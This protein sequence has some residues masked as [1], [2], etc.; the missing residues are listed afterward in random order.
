LATVR[1]A[2]SIV[3]I[4]RD[5]RL[6]DHVALAAAAE[7][8][9]DVIVAF[10][11]D[12]ALL[13]S[14]RIGA[15]LVQTFFEALRELRGSLRR[16]GSDLAVLEGDCGEQL[17]ALA[18]RSGAQ[19]VFFNEDYE[20]RAIARD[21]RAA[22]ALREAGVSVHSFLDHVCF[23]SDEIRTDADKPY[24]IFTPYRSRWRDRYAIGPRLPVASEDLIEGKLASP[25]EIGSTREIPEPE[26]YGFVSSAAYPHCG[27]ALACDLLEE[28]LE[29]GAAESYADARDFPALDATSHISVQLR[30][31]TIGIRTCFARAFSKARTSGHGSAVSKWIDELIWRE[32]Y[33]MI[34]R[35]FPYVAEG[36]FVRVAAG[37]HWSD[38]ED[39]F[40]RWCEGT[41]GYPIVDAGMRQL[42]RTGWMHNRLRMIVASFL[43][44]DLRINWQRGERYFETHLADADLASNNGG[45]QWAA[46]T[47]TDAVPYFRIFNP[48]TQGKRFDPDGAFVRAMVPELRGLAGSSVH[49]PWHAGALAI[50]GYPA[51]IVDHASARV[52]AL[53]MYKTVMGKTS[54]IDR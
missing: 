20:P 11:L 34:L 54:A 51:P 18:R 46:S 31:G 32:F 4:R 25:E 19:A 2:R 33:Q 22:V 44:K 9:G 42:N 30:A 37:L 49:E 29:G 12:P 45:W 10:N 7:R 23:G 16:H 17:T 38:D 8:S 1:Y 41:T 27:E 39:A 21:A 5:L 40:T 52:A 13:S 26:A 50:E 47:G 53:A 6:R 48:V 36:P 3:W 15:P 35:E 24:R 28:F 14:G 43:T